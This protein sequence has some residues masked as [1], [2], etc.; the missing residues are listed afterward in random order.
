[1][2]NCYK[3]KGSSYSVSNDYATETVEIR[4]QLWESAASERANGV[5]VSL[6]HEKLKIKDKCYISDQTRGERREIPQSRDETA[7]NL[8]GFSVATAQESAP[9]YEQH[10]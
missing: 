3:L 4:K 2:K 5:K 8:H 7:P 6:S 10:S 1:M 9:N